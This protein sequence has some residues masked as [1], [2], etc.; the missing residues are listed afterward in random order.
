MTD[1]S[2]E[3]IIVDLLTE[4]TGRHM[5]DSGDAYGRN[6]QRNQGKTLDT[7]MAEP[8]GWADKYGCVT[9]STF[10]WL[11]DR[12]DADADTE[13]GQAWFMAFSR[14]PD[15]DDEP[16]MVCAD[17]FLSR[18]RDGGAIEGNTDWI[19][20]Y[21]HED[22]VGQVL[23][24]ACF[25]LEFDVDLPPLTVEGMDPVAGATL[26]ADDYI[27]LQVHGGADVRGGY[28]HPHLFRLPGGFY[29]SGIVD[30]GSFELNCQGGPQNPDEAEG[31]LDVDGVPV[32]RSTVYHSWTFRD[33]YCEY[34]YASNGNDLDPIADIES[35]WFDEADAL[36]CPVCGTSLDVNA[37][38]VS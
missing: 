30:F 27:L 32:D 6:W 21:N 16:W 18:L 8:R 12:I 34:G 9:L 23:Q 7:F 13:A 24:F 36:L 35:L 4:N 19:N 1:I 11:R 20:T 26:P 37:L 28:T 25:T 10:H 5:L 14:T 29:E 38:S 15:L 22:V 3:Q 2:T 17:A 33:A 31:Q